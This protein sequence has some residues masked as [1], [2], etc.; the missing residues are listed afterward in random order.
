MMCPTCNLRPVRVVEGRRAERCWRC[1]RKVICR[2]CRQ[3]KRLGQDWCD[4]CNA[5]IAQLNHLH[6]RGRRPPPE[7]REAR[8]EALGKRASLGLPLF[9]APEKEAA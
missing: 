7:E 3:A 4:P 8:I 1:K 6:R 5:M 9:D 2:I